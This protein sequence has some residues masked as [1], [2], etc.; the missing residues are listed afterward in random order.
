MQFTIIQGHPDKS[1]QTALT[2]FIRY[3]D[4]PVQFS[5][6]SGSLEGEGEQKVYKFIRISKICEF[7]KQERLIIGFFLIESPEKNLLQ[8]SRIFIFRKYIRNACILYSNGEK[9]NKSRNKVT[10]QMED[11]SSPPSFRSNA[12]PLSAARDPPLSAS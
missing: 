9:K 2:S 6:W 4:L 3:I 1:Y 12:C 11:G 7:V 10:D 8:K 5:A